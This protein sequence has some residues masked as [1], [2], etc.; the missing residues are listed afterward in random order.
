M[1]HSAQGQGDGNWTDAYQKAR[2]L[3]SQLS[4]EEKN[5]I[6]NPSGPSHTHGCTGFTGTVER[7]GFPGICL[8]DG[9]SGF[10]GADNGSSTGFPAQIQI[11][12]SWS[13]DLA[14][15]RGKQMGI[16]FKAKGVNVALAP[17]VGPLG[18]VVLGGRNWVGHH[19]HHHHAFCVHAGDSVLLTLHRKAIRTIHTLQDSLSTPT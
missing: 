4:N 3:V 11:G 10:R 16:E 13:R 8:N 14:Y 17:V 5:N 1:T 19:H 18:R 9:P 7:L 15:Q 12:A 6:T 2:T